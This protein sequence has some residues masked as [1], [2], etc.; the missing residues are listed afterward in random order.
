MQG[1]HVY[2]VGKQQTLVHN[3]YPE[4]TAKRLGGLGHPGSMATVPKW[5]PPKVRKAVNSDI[6]HAAERAV[7][8]EVFVD[9]KSAANALRELGKKFK[10]EG[11]PPGTIPAPRRTDSVLVPFG[12]GHAVFEITKKG[13]AILRTV[14]RKGG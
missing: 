8:R 3:A 10:T 14:I 12:N 7:E 1:E 2:Y 11:L 9:T 13:T 6:A 5:T 4:D